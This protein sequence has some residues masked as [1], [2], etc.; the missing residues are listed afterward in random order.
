[1]GLI[2][3]ATISGALMVGILSKR[4]QI[5]TL[6]RW[7]LGIALLFIP[8]TL[9][10]TPMILQTGFWLP[11]VMFMLC[12]FIVVSITTLLSVFAVVRVQKIT[13]DN[14]LGKV[15]AIIQAV[16][17]CVAPIGQFLYGAAFEGFSGRPY[18]PLFIA[19]LLIVCSSFAWRVM[20][21]NE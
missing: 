17:Q 18:L 13:P 9:S 14:M 6:W 21:K 7:I 20:L 1:M 4:M 2:Q 10:V 15:M 8:M 19:C 11:F 5:N 12:I 3:L 16:A